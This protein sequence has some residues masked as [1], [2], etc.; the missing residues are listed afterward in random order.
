MRRKPHWLVLILTVAVSPLLALPVGADTTDASQASGFLTGPNE[1]EPEAIALAYFQ[2][3]AATYGLSGGD[4][5]DLAVRSSFVSSHTGVTHVHI[6]QQ[7]DGLEVFGADTTVSIAA[8]GSVVFVGGS[9]VSGLAA[10]AV[11]SSDAGLDATGAVEAAADELD[12]GEPQDVR[13]T[14]RKGGAA[15]ETVLTDGGIADSPITARL[16][17]QPSDDGLRLAWKLEIDDA[18]D[19]ALYEATIDAASGDLLEVEDWTSD[20]TIDELADRLGRGGRSPLAA[21]AIAQTTSITPGTTN[22]VNDGSSYRVYAPPKE[23]PND[24]GRT[25]QTNPAD[26]AASPWGWHD[27]DGATGAEFTITRGNN[28]HAYTDH[29][30]NNSPQG[31]ISRFVVDPP[32]SAA[33]EYAHTGAAFGPSATPDN[34]SGAI[35]LGDDGVDFVNDGCEPYT[36]PAGSIALVY[37]GQCNFTVKVANGQA[38]GASAVIVANNAPGA[39]I[40]MGGADPTITIPAIMITQADGETIQAGLPA[41]GAIQIIEPTTPTEPD[42]GPGLTFDFGLDLNDHP[43]DYAE[44]ATTNLFYWCNTAHDLFYLYGF[45]EASGNFQ[46]NNYGRGGTGGDYVRCE[47]QDGGGINNANFSTPGNDG[48]TPR[49]QMYLWSTAD[50]FRD[51]DLENGIIFHEYGHGLSLRLTG[52]PTQNCLS[53]NEQQGEGWSDYVA[54]AAT[55]DPALDDPQGPRGMGTYALN[56]DEPP[57]QGAGIRPRPYSRNMDIQP[58]TYDSIK[59]GAWFGGSLAIPH[60]IGHGW[61]S[62][63]WDMTWDLIDKHGFS[64]NIYEGWDSGG[65]ALA[66]QLVIDGLKLQGCGPGFVVSRDAILAADVPLTDGDNACTIWAAFARRGLGSSAVQGTTNRNDN[67]EAFDTHPACR[68][69]FQQPVNADYGDLNSVDAG[70][71]VPLRFSL[72]S[73]QGLDILASGSPYSREVD[74]DTLH[75]VSQLED[76]LTPRSVPVAAETP[77]GSGLSVSGRGVYTYPWK[78]SEDQ[79]GTCQELVLTRLDGVQHRAFFEVT[80]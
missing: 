30:N 59:T 24:G 15:R 20:H 78:T 46:A 13:T 74:C 73:N 53:G 69:D 35:A 6:N 7:F 34:F 54:I 52:G 8:D 17:W 39:P 50:P 14:R 5:A 4:V 49:M 63:L 18:D 28:V 21:T 42:G 75:P 27:T 64:D 19:P 60:H 58:F 45:D 41:S 32:S 68:E 67:D 11:R 12:L 40:T 51:G 62:I 29:N 10:S 37:R 57:R 77:G 26:G 3:E 80:D 9:S 38:G 72:G 47:A 16:G 55:I 79:A 33:G 76:S 71:T 25:L 22:P 2:D 23:S 61:A 66:Y 1:G 48:G 36:V 70:D 56:Q 43:H 31:G 44:A 65:N